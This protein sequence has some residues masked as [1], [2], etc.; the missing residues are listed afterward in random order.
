MAGPRPDNNGNGYSWETYPERL[1]RAGIS[2]RIYHDMDDYGC[3]MCKYFTQYQ[4]APKSRRS[5]RTP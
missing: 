4:Q 5:M 3:N 2:W 1:E